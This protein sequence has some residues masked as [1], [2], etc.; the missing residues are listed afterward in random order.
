MGII[1]G[2]V[3]LIFFLLILEQYVKDEEERDRKK[4]EDEHQ[5]KIEAQRL[6]NLKLEQDRIALEVYK[7]K[8]LN[9]GNFNNTGLN[10]Y[11]IIIWCLFIIIIALV[12]FITVW[13]I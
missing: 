9:K 5:R 6:H 11:Q 4:A 3:G 7:S 10:K 1:I 13:N 12:V 2:I 8:L